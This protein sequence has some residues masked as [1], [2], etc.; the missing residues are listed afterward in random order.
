[1]TRLLK[2]N[3]E[4]GQIVSAGEALPPF[5]VHCPLLS[6]PLVFRTDLGSIPRSNPYLTVDPQLIDQWK[7]RLGPK[8]G[9]F[10]VGLVWA[11][12]ALHK[13]DRQ[14]SLSL[15]E[16]LPLASIRNV[17]FYSLQKGRESEQTSA[18][19]RKMKLVDLTGK[20]EDFADTAALISQLDLVIGVDTAVI[21]LAA[22]MGKPAWLVLASV[23]DWRW[24]MHREDSPW[25]PT[26]RLFRQLSSC[27]WADVF[28]RVAGALAG[29]VQRGSS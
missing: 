3:P 1:L 28:K 2:F 12:S 10:R 13:R 4:L 24:L 14:R 17:E 6:L 23:P 18:I 19:A 27:D 16:F 15:S 29:E 8:S 22:A 21:H 11:G 25:Y 26:M 7:M 20:F 9:A 5:D